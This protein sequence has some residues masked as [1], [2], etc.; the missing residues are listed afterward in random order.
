VWD[1][2]V[3]EV[4]GADGVERVIVKNIKTDETR[5]IEANGLFVAIGH[6]PNSAF[7]QG[8]VHTDA[9]GYIVTE[10]SMRTSA[11]GMWA[12]GDVQDPKYRQAIT[13]AGSGCVA[14]L[15]IQRYLEANS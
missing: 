10:R 14:A 1:S 11:E 2:E 12:A 9:E 15:E 6:T 7:L 4:Q 8:F 5:T 13:A 3:A